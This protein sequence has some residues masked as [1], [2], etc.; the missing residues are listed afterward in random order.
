METVKSWSISVILFC[1][2]FVAFTKIGH[3]KPLYEAEMI[4]IRFAGWISGR[5]VS[6]Q[7]D[8]DIEKLL[9]NGNWIRM[10]FWRYDDFYLWDVQINPDY[11][12]KI[13]I[14][15]G[16]QRWVYQLKL[17]TL[18]LLPVAFRDNRERGRCFFCSFK[19][20]AKGAEVTFH[21]SI[22]GNF[23]VSKIYLKQI[24]MAAIHAAT[25]FMFFYISLIIFEVNI[26]ARQK[27]T[28]WW[29]IFCFL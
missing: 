17:C 2:V 3:T 6:L 15:N 11:F 1:L 29:R 25:T 23:M 12:C 27:Q 9:A 16:Q 13:L 24:C 8:T 20:E 19:K 21:N 5:I 18:Q 10:W 26:I 14:A 22:I 4:T 28:C 7:P